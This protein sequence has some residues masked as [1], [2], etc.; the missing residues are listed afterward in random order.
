[1]EKIEYIKN[2]ILQMWILWA[3]AFECPDR[4]FADFIKTDSLKLAKLTRVAFLVSAPLIIFAAPISF[5][6]VL[7]YFLINFESIVCWIFMFLIIAW[8]LMDEINKH[9]DFRLP[10]SY[11]HEFQFSA[12]TDELK[13][14]A[15]FIFFNDASVFDEIFYACY[16]AQN[17]NASKDIL[18]AFFLKFLRN[19]WGI[20][21]LTSVKTHV[22]MLKNEN[23]VTVHFYGA[24]SENGMKRLVQIREEEKSRM[25]KNNSD[26]TE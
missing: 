2:W 9:K 17:L 23:I 13:K 8:L 20:S 21:K 3:W 6:M 12:L 7:Y 24:F 14:H 16:T 4:D 15:D 25:L 26:L 18:E 5:L 1:M 22:I 19:F 11:F 10:F